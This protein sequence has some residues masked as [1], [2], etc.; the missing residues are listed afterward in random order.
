[1]SMWNRAKMA[2]QNSSATNSPPEESP[3]HRRTGETWILLH[4]WAPSPLMASIYDMV[5]Q[6][7]PS[8]EIIDILIARARPALSWHSTLIHWGVLDH[9]L[10][11]FKAMRSTPA[12]KSVD[13]AWVAMILQVRL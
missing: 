6:R 10:R 8:D 3:Y 11:V 12:L 9:E 7:L 2:T 5:L 4:D 13:P 1:M